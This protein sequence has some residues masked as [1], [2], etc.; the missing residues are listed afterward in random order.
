MTLICRTVK[1]SVVALAVCAILAGTLPAQVYSPKVFL[2]GQPDTTDL[3]LLADGIFAQAHATTPRQKAEAIWRFFLTDGRFVAPGFWYHIAGWSYEEPKGE[4][5]DPLKLL[6]S[7]GFGL[8]YHLAPLM[9]AV[10]D[11]AGFEDARVWFLTGHTVA[12]VFYEGG[13]HY[14]DSD[15]MG[16]NTLG[17]GKA[18][19]SPVA[20]VQEVAADAKIFLDKMD[21]PNEAKPIVDNPWYPADVRA[22]EIAG[23][24]GIFTSTADNWLFPF[25][26]YAQGH[27]ME[28]TLRPGEQLARYFGAEDNIFYLPFEVNK[29][30]LAAFPSQFGEYQIDATKGPGSQKDLR[31]WGTGRLEYRPP[32]ADSRAYYAVHNLTLNAQGFSPQN[33]AQPAFAIFDV[34]SPYVIIDAQFEMLVHM[35]EGGE[36][37]FE[38]STD[39]GRSWDLGTSLKGAYDGLWKPAPKVIT[40]T[41]HGVLTAV[42][43]QYSYLVRLTIGGSGAAVK[44]VLLRTRLQVNPRS[45]PVLSKGRNE[46]VYRP[47]PQ[48]RRWTVP[49][50]LEDGAKSAFRFTHARYVTEA[51]QGMMLPEGHQAAEMIYEL[52]TPDGSPLT[53]FDAGGRFLDLRNGIAPDKLNAET[54]PTQ[55]DAGKDLQ[56]VAASLEWSLTPEGPYQP[57][58]KYD[59][60][61]RWKDDKPVEQVLRWP[62]VDRQVR[63]LPPDTHKVYVKYRLAEM[64]IDDVRLSVIAAAGKPSP[65]EVIHVWFE[66]TQERSHVERIDD[67]TAEHAYTVTVPSAKFRNYGIILACR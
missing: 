32:L 15:L 6:N 16:Y 46:M 54:R 39:Q 9:Q 45:L 50:R 61:L 25:R 40:K 62:E 7:Y 20:S 14:F 59:P 49:V 3:R 42:G 48:Q 55:L 67:P 17:K 13:Y 2:K 58:W 66:G 34:N 12:E 35:P 51:Y 21:G 57:L 33:A 60:N 1:R 31:G 37:T 43:G 29:R 23:I 38:T 8:C 5:L 27:S 18:K 26:R 11:A 41:P 30:G 56:A 4:V 65:L 52:A 64:A 44:D 28:F 53:G 10:Y 36:L 24:A 19:T 47:G 63:T 22:G